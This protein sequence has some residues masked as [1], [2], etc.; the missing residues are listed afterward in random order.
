MSLGGYLAGLVIGGL[1]FGA[2][3]AYAPPR[4][5]ARI[6]Y[7][8]I[9]GVVVAVLAGAALASTHLGKPVCLLIA[10]GAAPLGAYP[11]A[12]WGLI[13]GDDSW[14]GGDGW[15]WFGGGGDGDGGDGGG[16][17]D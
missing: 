8:M 11:G 15:D 2:L 9:I 12:R 14:I 16:D 17:G 10:L 13:S 3:A 7:S 1:V 6:A 5:T 4:V